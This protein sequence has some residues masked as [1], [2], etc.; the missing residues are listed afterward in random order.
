VSLLIFFIAQAI[1]AQNKEA[2]T[3]KAPTRETSIAPGEPELSLRAG[4]GGL[5]FHQIA[6]KPIPISKETV[7]INPSR[8][9]VTNFTVAF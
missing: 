9:G 4:I 2:T 8:S 6:S 3:S 7:P 1:D 5:C